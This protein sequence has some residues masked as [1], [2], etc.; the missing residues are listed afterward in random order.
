MSSKQVTTFNHA[1]SN[2]P[3]D[4]VD[5]I[6]EQIANQCTYLVEEV[7][8]LKEAALARNFVKLADGHGDTKFVR[9]YLDDLVDALGLN[10]G[11]IFKTISANNMMKTTTSEELAEK[12]KAEKDE[13]G[14]ET[15]VAKVEFEGETYYTVRRC[16]DNK[17]MK[18][19]DFP[20][21]DL[22]PFIPKRLLKQ[23]GLNEH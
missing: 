3:A 22:T 19:R 9:D 5:D 18:F 6:L 21:M 8:E 23:G 20:E 14:I 1:C 13:D 12:W 11:G 7:L 2:A 15:Y 4:T 10:R 17:I 16:E